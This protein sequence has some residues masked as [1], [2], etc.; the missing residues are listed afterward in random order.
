VITSGLAILAF[1]VNGITI[2]AKVISEI[3]VIL[4]E[5]A[6]RTILVIWVRNKE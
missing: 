1:T 3:P 6:Q 2:L 5:D 4:D